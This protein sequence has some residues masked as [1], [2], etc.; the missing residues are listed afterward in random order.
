M[1]FHQ[2]SLMGLVHKHLQFTEAPFQKNIHW[3]NQPV[4]TK[5]IMT[6]DDLCYITTRPRQIY[7]FHN[8][9]VVC[10]IFLLKVVMEFVHL[11]E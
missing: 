3:K 1:G 7:I 5:Q 10:S 6:I 9:E 11:I 4:G 8:F 2:N